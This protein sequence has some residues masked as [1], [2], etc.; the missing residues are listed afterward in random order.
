MLAT[1]I[2]DKGEWEECLPKV[3]LAY[4]TSEHCATGFTLFYMMFGRQANMPLH[5]MYGTPTKS[6]KDYAHYTMN[7]WKTLE[8]AYQIA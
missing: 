3:W 8:Q 7:L 6:S 5:L 4:N 1:V 2:D